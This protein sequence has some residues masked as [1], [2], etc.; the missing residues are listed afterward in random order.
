M[1]VAQ[2]I[3]VNNAYITV[4]HIQHNSCWYNKVY[5]SRI[6]T[7]DGQHTDQQKK[8][9]QRSTRH[10]TNKTKIKLS[11]LEI[12]RDRQYNVNWS[13]RSEPSHLDSWISNGNIYTIKQTCTDLFPV[14]KNTYF[15]K[16]NDSKSMD[17]TISGSMSDLI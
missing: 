6:S 4:K 8:D 10:Y 15:H 11:K 12:A 9:K 17:T 2:C 3:L 1:A 14:K 5:L 16:M 13:I 7:K